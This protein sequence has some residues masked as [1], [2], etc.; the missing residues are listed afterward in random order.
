MMEGDCVQNV[1]AFETLDEGLQE[2]RGAISN[3]R[4]HNDSA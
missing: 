1:V 3:G 2:I 4:S